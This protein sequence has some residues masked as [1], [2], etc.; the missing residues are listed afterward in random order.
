MISIL[1][2]GRR[3]SYKHLG[4]C[5]TYLCIACYLT[6]AAISFNSTDPSWFYTSTSA[7][8]VCNWGGTVG[9]YCAA[10][11]FFLC[12]EAALLII[13]FFIFLAR[14]VIAPLALKYEWDRIAAWFILIMATSLMM[15]L[16][17]RSLF[18]DVLPGGALGVLLYSSLSLYFDRIALLLLAGTLMGATLLLITRLALF[19]AIYNG[20]KCIVWCILY[21]HLAYGAL[22]TMKYGIT[23]IHITCYKTF[24]I[25]H[26]MIVGSDA[27]HVLSPHTGT[28]EQ[29]IQEELG[30]GTAEDESFWQAYT[31]LKAHEPQEHSSSPVDTPE[32]VESF[33]KE[34]TVDIMSFKTPVEYE[35]PFVETLFN[36]IEGK[37]EQTVKD[38]NESQ[39]LAHILEE[40][41]ERF[42]VRGKVLSIH[43]GPVI[44]LFEYE[45]HIDSK[46]SK[47]IALED[48][49]TL[50]LQAMSIR[51][52]APIPGRSVVGFEVANKHR[53]SVLFSHM[54]RS[55][56]FKEF[57]GVLPLVLGENVVGEPLIVDLVTMPHLLVAGSTG[58][59]KSVGLNA[60]LMSLLC[61][62]KPNALKLIL[63]DPKRLEFAAYADTPHLL[64]P[65]V[66]DPKSV[67]PI[68]KWVVHTMEQRY[69]DM[70]RC[71]V[72]NIFD[73]QKLAA[74]NNAHM[75]MPFIVVIIDELSDLMMTAGKEI[76]DLIAR[77]AQMARAA[78]IHMIV[79]TQR[80][81]VDV[82]TGLIKVNFPSRIAFKVIS[83]IDSRTI[84]D[85]NGADK[86]LGK[87]DML[88]LDS[89]SRLQR[90]HG[91]YV[92]DEE[93][94]S[95]VQY[96]K[97]QQKVEYVDLRN[98]FFEKNNINSD[99]DDDLYKDIVTYIESI[100]EVSISLLQRKFKIGYNR[101]ARIIDMLES[102]G[103]IM[104]CH[105]GKMRKVIRS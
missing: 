36:K 62:L 55:K 8:P 25:V 72:R 38:K 14:M 33:M 23:F 51:I 21:K 45:P 50:A 78:G 2:R 7:H 84:L 4:V 34:P 58:S 37:K 94:R 102:R 61:K 19:Y 76:E 56:A 77:I 79:A 43:S 80:P 47:I 57:S 74:Q 31:T 68:L 69:S 70:A 24:S 91:A 32:R 64:F 9:A 29:I 46:I 105:G 100:D 20:A 40:K 6:V 13:P 12:G 48:D 99:L 75:P 59:G 96:S 30:I 35:L 27:T 17:A 97:Q 90:V 26:R 63:I 49:L 98:E 92:H 60:I 103:L 104:A 22:Y 11:L 54:V 39:L 88:F 86:L 82:I 42:G 28:L 85:C 3:V 53:K 5:V 15:K 16:C 101:S 1:T 10:L 81:S 93:I 89:S 66:T 44:T 65:I 87:G 83:K 95:L 71:N 18:F 41:L 52:I 73:Y 67:A